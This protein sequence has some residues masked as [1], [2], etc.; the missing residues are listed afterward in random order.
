MLRYIAEKDVSQKGVHPIIRYRIPETRMSYVFIFQRRNQRSDVYA[1]R[2]CKKKHN[3]HM[4]V[5]VVGNEIYDDPCKNHKCCPIN[6]SLDRANRIMYEACQ[7][8]K[9]TAELASTSVMEVWENTLQVAMTEETSREEVV[10]HFYQRGLATRRKSIQR[11]KSCHTDHSINWSCVPER[12]AK[13]SNGAA[14][15]QE[16]TPM[17]H[18]YFSDDTLRMACEQGIKALIGWYT[19]N[20]AGENG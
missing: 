9:N 6:A 10:A 1:C 13:L 5:R 20:L 4:V 7:K 3:H 16:L 14:F 12:Y 17:Y 2:A 19:Q 11:A 18:L 15:L 8:I